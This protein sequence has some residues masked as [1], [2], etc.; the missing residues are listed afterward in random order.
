LKQCREQVLNAMRQGARLTDVVRGPGRADLLGAVEADGVALVRGRK[1]IL[2]GQTPPESRVLAIL[3][4]LREQR[5]SDMSP[6]Y[7]TDCLSEHLPDMAAWAGQAAGVALFS[8]DPASQ[9]TLMWFRGEQLREISWGGDPDKPVEIGDDGRINPRK[10]FAAW[11]QTVRLRSRRWWLEQRQS[12]M[13]LGGLIDIEL[14]KEIEER[15]R[16]TETVLK[17]A[18]ETIGEG[19]AVYDARD[20]LVHCNQEYLNLYRTSAE[21]IE[22]GRTFEEILRYGLARG[23]YPDAV[24]REEAWLEER[25]RDHHREQFETLQQLDDGRWLK[26]RERRTPD[27]FHV[28]IRVD[29]TELH[30]ARLAAESANLAKSRFVATISHE[31]RTPLNGITGM[32]QLLKMPD[33]STEERLDYA[34]TLINSSK[35]LLALLN[36]ILDFSKVEAGK[37]KLDAVHFQP[38]ALLREIQW[39]FAASAQEK[40]LNY[41]VAWNNDPERYYRADAHRLRQMLANLVNN[42]IKF[43]D[44]GFVRVEATEL[45][46]QTGHLLLEFAVTDS[47]PGILLEQQGDL[48]QPFSQVGG[49]T[50]RLYGGTGLGLSIVRRLARLMGGEAGVES[51]LGAGARYWIRI[52]ADRVT[53]AKP[54]SVTS[55]REL[56]PS[57]VQS[58]DQG[59]AESSSAPDA[60]PAGHAAPLSALILVVDDE[61]TNRKLM[62]ALLA[63]LK[64]RVAEAEHGEQCL[65]QLRAGLAP[66]LILMDCRMPVLNG[67]ETTRAIRKAPAGIQNSDVPVIALTAAAFAEDRERAL[68][69][70]MND[71][72]AKPVLFED[73]KERLNQ[74][75]QAVAEGNSA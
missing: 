72:L 13:E 3:D 59:Q 33:L 52:P 44:S 54:A 20:R 57:A 56:P 12:A 48:F 4:G 10:S 2:G 62:R 8:L 34:D 14:R 28:G 32:A 16:R 68:A 58:T 5:P 75:L 23:Q 15:L 64:Y 53:D 9:L 66:D 18:I 19:F 65:E 70:G 37:L 1:V 31:I 39:L 63:K 69:A 67:Y 30:Q 29:V 60:T 6:L 43:T 25:L 46:T 73:L 42:A 35:T 40:G 7:V 17:T 71:L 24:G 74:W 26:V 38:V 47:G 21:Y 22:P 61:A 11:S 41:E 45:E 27:G 36:D 55:V 51:E 50:A 49:S